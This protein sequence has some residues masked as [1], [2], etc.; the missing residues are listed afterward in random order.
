MPPRACSS[1]ARGI[2]MLCVLCVGL[3]VCL[4][5]DSVDMLMWCVGVSKHNRDRMLSLLKFTCLVSI[6]SMLSYMYVLP[7]LIGWARAFVSVFSSTAEIDEVCKCRDTP[8]LHFYMLNCHLLYMLYHVLKIACGCL[9][10]ISSCLA[11]V[12]GYL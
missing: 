2:L 6:L 9:Q 12:V 8:M 5:V 1:I 11:V 3:P 10:V 4:C 7:S